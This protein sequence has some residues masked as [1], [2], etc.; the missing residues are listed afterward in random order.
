MYKC[1]VD[2]DWNHSTG[3]LKHNKTNLTMGKKGEM[4][5]KLLLKVLGELTIGCVITSVIVI[6]LLSVMGF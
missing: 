1:I 3:M 6:L 2:Y 5:M 4:R